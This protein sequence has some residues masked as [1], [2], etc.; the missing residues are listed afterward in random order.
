MDDL[1]SQLKDIRGIDPV[2]WWPPAPGWWLA[3]VVVIIPA[4]IFLILRRRKLAYERS[5]RAEIRNVF[6]ELRRNENKSF[7]Q[8]AAALS[9]L[10]RGLAI[11]RYGRNACAGLQG[12]NWLIWLTKNDPGGFS[13]DKEGALLIEA[14]YLPEDGVPEVRNWGALLDA[15]ER[16]MK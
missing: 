7:K 11:K 16:W 4:V 6:L 8:R 12:K 10:L 13:W 3:P 15:A 2:S 1:L 9:G 14:P 5:W